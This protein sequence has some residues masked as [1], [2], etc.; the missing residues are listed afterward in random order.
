LGS[1]QNVE[2]DCGVKACGLLGSSHCFLQNLPASSC[3][4][5][6]SR[7]RCGDYKS[8]IPPIM[9]NILMTQAVNFA[10]PS[11]GADLHV[12]WYVELERTHNDD[13]PKG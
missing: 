2:L 7:Y 11:P 3:P 9:S 6:V 8:M 10:A 13:L 1:R 12:W 4:F 5:Y